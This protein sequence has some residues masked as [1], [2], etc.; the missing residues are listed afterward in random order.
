MREDA[1]HEDAYD[2]DDV[3]PVADQID[4]DARYGR[5]DPREND[6]TW[7]D[8]GVGWVAGLV[9]L[10]AVGVG[11]GIWLGVVHGDP[12]S[13]LMIPLFMLV[14]GA[15]V[16]AIYGIPVSIL[17]ATVLRP[18]RS[19]IVHLA[20]FLAAGVLGA[21]LLELLLGGFGVFVVAAPYAA[22]AAVVG[23][24]VAKRRAVRRVGRSHETLPADPG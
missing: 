11:Q 2:R 9:A 5:P 18:V 24:F 23:R 6:W 10:L 16:L 15:A 12:A 3:H 13:I 14:P 8:I 4:M 7:V 21:A 19:E 20:V 1:R 17:L 22:A